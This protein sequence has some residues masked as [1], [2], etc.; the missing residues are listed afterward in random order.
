MA[1]DEALAVIAEEGEQGARFTSI[2]LNTRGWLLRNLGLLAEADAANLEA[3]EKVAVTM[4][5]G[6]P[7]HVAHLDLL[8]GAIARDDRAGID[9]WLE[10]AS[11]VDGWDGGMSWRQKARLDL[12]RSRLALRNDD[13]AVAL[14]LASSVQARAAAWPVPRYRLMAELV[15]DEA[16]ATA[17]AVDHHVD[18]V[19]V[20][21]RLHALAGVAAPEAWWRTAELA[22]VLGDDDLGAEAERRAERL[23]ASAA[24]AGID[25]S[26]PV[27]ARLAAIRA[28]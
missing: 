28:R 26:A 12:L 20:A 11:A 10:E 23:V 13:P 22:V 4:L 2:F 17:G 5:T 16:A 7:F 21:G 27:A 3:L 19:A 18:H 6:E 24:S 1:V 14:S 15:M 8:D 9:R 25:A